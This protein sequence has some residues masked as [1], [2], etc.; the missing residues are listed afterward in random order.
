MDTLTT[1]ALAIAKLHSKKAR[2]NTPAY[3]HN[4]MK[5]V[6]VVTVQVR[7]YHVNVQKPVPTPIKK[8]ISTNMK[9]TNIN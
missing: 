7:V 2:T 9:D 8:N 5:D 3:V 6:I 1:F 4:F